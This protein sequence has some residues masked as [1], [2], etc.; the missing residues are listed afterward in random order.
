MCYICRKKI[1]DYS[2]F[3]NIPPNGAAENPPNQSRASNPE[4]C[5]LYSDTAKMHEDEV[6]KSAARARAELASSNPNIRVDL[7]LGKK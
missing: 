1:K 5:P 6:A 4:K 3:S 7:V 2:H